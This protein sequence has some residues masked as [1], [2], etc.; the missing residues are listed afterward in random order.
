MEAGWRPGDG[1]NQELI[2]EEMRYCSQSLAERGVGSSPLPNMTLPQCCAG[3]AEKVPVGHPAWAPQD[4]TQCCTLSRLPLPV[5]FEGFVWA[6]VHWDVALA[7]K[8]LYSVIDQPISSNDTCKHGQNGFASLPKQSLPVA[9]YLGSG[10]NCEVKK[11][12]DDSSLFKTI[13][14]CLPGP[15][16]GNINFLFVPSLVTTKP[17]Y[18]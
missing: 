5:P 17:K 10:V 1:A 7:W 3:M 4:R 16:A 6:R 15:L 8:L 9:V 18:T 12:E 2:E 13:N 14:H 11:W